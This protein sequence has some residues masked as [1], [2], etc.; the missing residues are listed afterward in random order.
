MFVDLRP[1][2]WLW[3][4]PEDKQYSLAVL[5]LACAY[6][7]L[8]EFYKALEWVL[9]TYG[10]LGPNI[11]VV[12]IVVSLDSQR[13]Y[14]IYPLPSCFYSLHGHLHQSGMRGPLLDF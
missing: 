11:R 9:R 7:A 14:T 2:S 8:G 13:I 5:Y 1:S 3:R 10:P 6:R 12:G 4:W